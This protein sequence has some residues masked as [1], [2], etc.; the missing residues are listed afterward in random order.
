MGPCSLES[1]AAYKYV[2]WIQIRCLFDAPSAVVGL[3]WN[4]QQTSYPVPRHSCVSR[5]LFGCTGDPLVGV[6][7]MM[8]EA[9]V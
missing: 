9:V 8:V 4:L 5:S 3:P 7:G 2:L 6:V 1:H